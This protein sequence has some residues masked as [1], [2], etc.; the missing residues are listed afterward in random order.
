MIKVE[1]DKRFS[2]ETLTSEMRKG[3]SQYAKLTW[4]SIS[5]MMCPETG[6]PSDHLHYPRAGEGLISEPNRVD[7]TNLTDIGFSLACAGAAASMG[8][9]QPSEAR[10][11]IDQTLTTL[12]QMTT[13][14]ELFIP[15]TSGKGLLANWITP[16]TG[17]VLKEWPGSISAVKKHVSTVDMAWLMAFSKMTGAQFPQ[18]NKRI[19]SYLN[20]IDL[21][22]MFDP[23]S[24]FFHGCYNLETQE[25]EDWE[26]KVISEARIAYLVGDQEMAEAMSKMIGHRT[27]QSYVCDSYGRQ[28]RATYV[29]AFFE[30]GW[31]SLL[32]PED[33]LNP[34][35]ADMMQTTIQMQK[36]YGATHS[37]GHYGFSP[38]LG[39]DDQYHIYRVPDA[40]ESRDK[41]IEPTGVITV[42][43]LVNMGLREPVE[44]YRALARLHKE[45]PALVNPNYGDGDTVDTKTGNVQIDQLMHNQAAILLTCWNVVNHHEPQ[46]IFMQAS[47]D[48][49]GIYQRYQL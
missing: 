36:D 19:Q 24:G 8:F 32:I 47:P 35:W 25:F 14:L 33:E 23:E 41:Y 45:F 38:G 27:E 17:K 20:K 15:T 29:G 40:G 30:M 13:D 44:T 16:S 48:I 2:E 37:C 22:F 28:S 31:P 46:D 1:H 4:N 34:S 11:R 18:F 6:L 21:A 12:E 43:A 49:A 3:Y 26:Y 10:Q 39:P 9:I 5:A 42:A 7:K